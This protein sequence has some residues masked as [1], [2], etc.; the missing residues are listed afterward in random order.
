MYQNVIF[1]EYDI[2]GV[3]NGEF[4]KDFAYQLGKAFSSYLSKRLNKKDL[5]VT[6]GHDARLSCPEIKASLTKGFLE[7]GV[8]V[9]QLGLVTTPVCYFSTFEV[10]GIDGAVQITGSHNP[11][12]YNGFKISFGKSTIFG[13]EIQ[14]L[15]HII[16]AND[17]IQGSGSES[18]YDIFP[19][20]Y[21]RY[22]KEFGNIKP[23]KVILDCG[24]GAGGSVVRG[25][26]NAVGLDPVI[27]FEKPDGTFPNHHPDPTVEK[28]LKHLRD[29]VLK[30][31]AVCGIGFDGDADRIGVVDHT[32]KMLY[33]DE[34]MVI[35]SRAILETSKG[36]KIIGDVKCS[37]RLY[38]D[39]AK[40]GGVPV[41][42]KTGHSLIK[43]KVKSEKSPFGGEMSGHIFFADR[44]YGY[45]DAPYAA[46]RLVEILSKTGKTITQLLEGLPPAFNTPEI[47]IDTTEEKKVLIVEKMKEAFSKGGD[48]K[49]NLTDGIRISFPYGWALCRASNTQPVLVLRYESESQDGL[50]K[51][52]KQVE[53]I[54]NPLL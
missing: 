8:N 13:E 7:S 34:L 41:M 17:F 24:N 32:G 11:P 42:W 22:K 3:Y 2:R 27:L 47:R 37:D 51:I 12:E 21:A 35:I 15:R 39:I 31:G 43:E 40:H 5:T 18:T 49:V 48:Y 29:E 33:G 10:P 23:V 44:N 20:Y 50:N 19:Q 14:K 38:D 25:L 54:V 28:N 9:K 16:E 36:A 53:A 26:F 6:I 45:D 52:Q 46:V 1:R 4:D 30:T